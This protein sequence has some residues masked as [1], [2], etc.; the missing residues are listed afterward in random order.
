MI[1]KIPSRNARRGFTLVEL[2]VSLAVLGITVLIFTQAIGGVS[3]AWRSAE[4]R[5]N[6]HNKARALLSRLRTDIDAMVLRPDLVAFP[7][8]PDEFGFYTLRRGVDGGGQ[9]DA[10]PLSYVTYDFESPASSRLLRTDVG[11]SYAPGSALAF[12]Q[13][14]PGGA[15]N[16]AE[17]PDRG[18]PP[19]DP[20]LDVA[21]ADGVIGF[22]WAFLKHDGT[23]SRTLDYIDGGRARTAKALVV[24]MAVM[25][26]RAVTA[27]QRARGSGEIS[28]LKQAFQAPAPDPQGKWNPKAYWDDILGLY[29]GA[30]GT[31]AHQYPSDFIRGIR[32]FERTYAFPPTN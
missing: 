27:L 13:A 28:S 18:T 25:D 4:E 14:T 32:T 26:D 17:P 12:A 9:P 7:D 2:M 21:L 31:V 10:R 6:N 19:P 5:M 23:F 3:N 16:P 30:S 29:P 22:E 11:Y 24:A 15:A 20:A 1:R 8:S